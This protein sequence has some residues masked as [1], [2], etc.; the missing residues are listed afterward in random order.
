MPTKKAEKSCVG[1]ALP[2]GK[3]GWAMPTKKAEELSCVGWALRAQT[4][5]AQTLRAQTLR[6]QTLRPYR[7]RN[8]K[9]SRFNDRFSE[10][11]YSLGVNFS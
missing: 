7:H 9:K 10:Y 1:W 4:L 3:V 6:A 11:K 5:R 8:K 2:T